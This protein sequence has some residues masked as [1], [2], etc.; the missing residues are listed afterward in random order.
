MQPN[1][2]LAARWKARLDSSV[3]ILK[4]RELTIVTPRYFI[5][6]THGNKTP[7]KEQIRVQITS[8]RGPI[9]MQEDFLG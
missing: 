8:L 6:L 9:L 7:V 3:E 1:V 2:A 4:F 5:S